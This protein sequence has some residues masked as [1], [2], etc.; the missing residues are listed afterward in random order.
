MITV[1][2][3][4]LLVAVVVILSGVVSSPPDPDVEVA[5]DCD[6]EVVTVQSAGNGKGPSQQLV[7]VS[8]SA[9]TGGGTAFLQPRVTQYV[10]DPANGLSNT[11][12]YQITATIG[13]GKTQVTETFDVDQDGNGTYDA[14]E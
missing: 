4:N 14:C 9:P 10:F 2:T 7:T 13:R 1:T 5:I 11:D 12:I 3:M 6:S 8:S